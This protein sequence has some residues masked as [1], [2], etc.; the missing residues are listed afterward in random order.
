MG[1]SQNGNGLTI[2]KNRGADEPATI[3]GAGLMV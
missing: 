2:E 3:C 1:N